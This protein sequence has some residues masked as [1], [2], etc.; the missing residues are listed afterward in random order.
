MTNTDTKKLCEYC[1]VPIQGR[2]DKRFCDDTCRTAFNN[3]ARTD[4]NYMRNVNNYLRKNRR[5][6]SELL[7]EAPD[8][9]RK[10]SGKKMADKGYNFSYHTNIYT[11]Q[12]GDSYIFC[13]EYGYLKLEN[14][15]YMIVKRNET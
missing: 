5:I 12:K 10:V 7:A 2:S 15:I 8:G 9:K 11:T 4:N 14:D 1:Q 6:M 13:Y 3:L